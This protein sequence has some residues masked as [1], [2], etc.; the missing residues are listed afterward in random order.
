MG[1]KWNKSRY[2][3]SEEKGMYYLKRG[4]VRKD[5]EVMLELQI[6]ID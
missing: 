1:I 6:A 5:K 2:M 4:R 3:V